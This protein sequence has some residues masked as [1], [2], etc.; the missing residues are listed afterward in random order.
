[1]DYLL[2]TPF[3]ALKHA[4]TTCTSVILYCFCGICSCTN[5]QKGHSR[6]QKP[7][8]IAV[9]FS[10][11]SCRT[12]E[13][14]AKTAEFLHKNEP[15]LRLLFFSIQSSNSIINFTNHEKTILCY[16]SYFAVLG[17]YR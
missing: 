1:M 4:K 8:V 13:Q 2:S 14:I 5:R 6:N 7:A 10:G 9:D 16:R 3:K 15:D 12:K 17:E 11:L